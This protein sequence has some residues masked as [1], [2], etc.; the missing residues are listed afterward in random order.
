MTRKCLNCGS[1]L[2]SAILSE[3]VFD[4]EDL[5][6]TTVGAK[7]VDVPAYK[8]YSCAD[9]LVL[10]DSAGKI[11]MKAKID[12]LRE[13]GFSDEMINK[14]YF[15][16]Q[17]PDENNEFEAYMDYVDFM[18]ESGNPVDGNTFYSD[19]DNLIAL[20]PHCKGCG[21]VKVKIKL[22]EVVRKPQEKDFTKLSIE[23]IKK[24]EQPYQKS[25]TLID[26]LFS[27]LREKYNWTD[28]DFGDIFDC[29]P[30]YVKYI[31]FKLNVSQLCKICSK[32]GIDKISELFRIIENGTEGN[33]QDNSG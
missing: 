16:V 22:D 9:V 4:F 27:T 1:Y 33:E 12:K 26:N 18:Y 28:K 14:E 24:H 7:A 13:I 6:G 15:S 23:E 29:S 30:D 25:R 32:I 19:I 10:D 3:Y 8:C 21:I 11:I 17:F 20:K 2:Y 5:N 31:S